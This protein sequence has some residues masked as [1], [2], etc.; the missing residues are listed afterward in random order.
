MN[1]FRRLMKEAANRRIYSKS[2]G[3][4]HKKSKP[5]ANVFQGD[6]DKSIEEVV[7]EIIKT[8][9][10]I[11]DGTEPF[12]YNGTTYSEG[13]MAG[14]TVLPPG[15]YKVTKSGPGWAEFTEG[16][17]N[18]HPLDSVTGLFRIGAYMTTNE[19]G[20][21][22]MIPESTFIAIRPMLSELRKKLSGTYS[23][24]LSKAMQAYRAQL[25]L[26]QFCEQ[27][28]SSTVEFHKS[29]LIYTQIMCS[30]PNVTAVQSN[31][32]PITTFTPVDSFCGLLGVD[33]HTDGKFSQ[34]PEET[35]LLLDDY[36][37]RDDVI[38]TACGGA[39]FRRR[40]GV[41]KATF[42]THRDVTSHRTQMCRLIG[43]GL[44]PFVEYG[45]TAVNISKGLRRLIKA[46]PEE[47]LFRQR[48]F[49][50]SRLY[51]KYIQGLPD[52]KVKLRPHVESMF[53]RLRAGRRFGDVDGDCPYLPQPYISG[54]NATMGL[55]RERIAL[56]DQDVVPHLFS[57]VRQ[58][59]R[60][61][62]ETI[63][64]PMRDAIHWTYYQG[65][66]KALE[67]GY[68]FYGREF[69][70]SIP[71]VKE[72]LRA[73]Y[74]KGVLIH[75]SENIMVRRLNACVKK[76]L[77][78][79][80]KAPRL[81]VSY[82]AGCMYANELPEYMKICIDGLYYYRMGG[83]DITFHVMA[84]P[85]SD[86]LTRIFNELV[87]TFQRPNS[88]F[89][90]IYS[91][92]MCMSVNTPLFKFMANVDISSNDSNQDVLQF[93]LVFHALSRF[94][95]PLAEGLIKQCLQKIRVANP[96]ESS[97]YLDLEFLGPFQGSG[98]T[99]TTILNHTGNK[100][101][102][103]YMCWL[104]VNAPDG[105]SPED[106]IILGAFFGGHSVT[107]SMCD[108]PH[109]LQ[110]LKRSPFNQ[111]G[112]WYPYTNYGCIFR[113]FGTVDGDLTHDKL[114][115]TTSE[116]RCMDNK[117]RMDRF[118]SGVVAGLCHEPDSRIMT[119]L[120]TR[121]PSSTGR[122]GDFV[123]F[124]GED[125]DVSSTYIS[126]EDLRARY[127]ITSNDIDELVDQIS[128]LQPGVVLSSRACAR[129]YQVDYE[130]GV[131]NIHA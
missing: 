34:I 75:E 32:M 44:P 119:A 40:D 112:K 82:D 3:G 14:W 86:S 85:K 48:N 127:D 55:T 92:D 87:K 22:V 93:L 11:C 117:T 67:I 108:S 17:G 120:R 27:L 105:S 21:Q 109:E 38:I 15:S 81:F 8:Y 5:K 13:P 84:K 43:L 49:H 29:Y 2:C 130:V 42:P 71:H 69:C 23:E 77:A 80:N 61:T 111:D 9:A 131:M 128:H 101:N 45:N 113:S 114:G 66:I 62:I 72:K 118:L 59:K 68:H 99:L 26:P 98:T 52:G 41:D 65:F 24:H 94:S 95:I 63:M 46:R 78:K 79:Y 124:G 110:F 90:A 70:A 100:V 126:D 83:V 39:E 73:S 56:M 121:F 7:P 6:K 10:H 35:C 96:H 16:K 50:V 123:K 102:C 74:V 1:E 25:N 19:F 89:V 129:F 125:Y 91:D 36:D 47:S 116:F 53:H 122:C 76:E 28:A 64:D 60:S 58:N 20:N 4:T 97:E 31:G 51:T 30:Q 103:L 88:I 115:V 106:C 54:V 18:M 33:V 57:Y 104:L 107:V 37:V 12:Y